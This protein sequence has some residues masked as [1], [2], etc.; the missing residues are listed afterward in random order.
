M[1]V[2]IA[3]YATTGFDFGAIMEVVDPS[4]YANGMGDLIW[5]SV[6]LESNLEGLQVEVDGTTVT[7]GALEVT[8]FRMRQTQE[9]FVTLIEE[10]TRNPTAIEADPF[11]FARRASESIL[12]LAALEAFAVRDIAVDID[13]AGALT[14]GEIALNDLDNEGIGA[15][16]VAD[17]AFDGGTNGSGS[18]DRFAIQDIVYG[19]TM[20]LIEHFSTQM[21]AEPPFDLVLE[22]IPQVGWVSLAGLSVSPPGAQEPITVASMDFAASNFIGGLATRS[23]TALSGVVVPTS[24]IDDAEARSQI[25]A[26]GF[27]ELDVDLSMT[28]DWDTDTGRFDVE[29][30]TFSVTDAGTFSFSSEF[31]GVP[32]S[33]FADPTMIESRMLEGNFVSGAVTFGN[34]GIV[35][36]ALAYYA[37]QQGVN[38]QTFRD[39]IAGFVTLG[40]SGQP[41]LAPIFGTAVNAFLAD[42]QSFTIAAAPQSPISF[43]QMQNL[44]NGDPMAAAQMFNLTAAANE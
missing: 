3:S 1:V 41:Q 29:D 23:I 28:S 37:E 17:V 26:L 33:I 38:E 43:L 31:G 42:P 9:P 5:R 12:G 25:E 11:T 14:I 32:L 18:L 13:G 34:A 24:L 40:L 39:Q 22:A 21:M 6:G 8:G 7:I 20:P 27:T 10:A 16:R 36:R 4:R 35:E 44:G 15:I 2:R 30:V 19:S